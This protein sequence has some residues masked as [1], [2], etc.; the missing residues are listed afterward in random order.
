MKG[1]EAPRERPR[2]SVSPLRVMVVEDSEY[3]AMLLVEELRRGNYEP[4][5]ER[6]C[7]AEEMEEALEG[8]RGEDWQIVVSDYYMPRFSG[9]DALALLRRLGYNTPFIVVSGKIGEEAAVAM[10]RA[11]AQDYVIKDNMARLCPAIERELRE[12]RS[13]RS[14]KRLR[15]RSKR[16]RTG[17]GVW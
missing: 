16:A 6:V 7:T 10:M 17:S 12:L 8:A 3:D 9:P 14:A 11:G 4:V 2:D 5:Y 1:R 15:R 13:A